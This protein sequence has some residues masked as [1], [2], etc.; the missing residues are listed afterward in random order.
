MMSLPR[1]AIILNQNANEEDGGEGL[2]NSNSANSVAAGSSRKTNVDDV[3]FFQALSQLDARDPTI[4]QEFMDVYRYVKVKISGISDCI[5]FHEKTED[6]PD[7]EEFSVDLWKEFY[8][9]EGI[10]QIGVLEDKEP[11][12]GLFVGANSGRVYICGQADD[13]SQQK[14]VCV[15]PSLYQLIWKGPEQPVQYKPACMSNG[16]YGCFDPVMRHRLFRFKQF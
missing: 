14:C 16:C 8:I 10:I 15:A 6:S 5:S 13:F 4:L 1:Y 12:E 2:A 3:T 7:F 9:Q 11:T